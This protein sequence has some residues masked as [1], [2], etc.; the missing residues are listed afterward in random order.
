MMNPW[1]DVKIGEGAPAIVRGIIEIPTNTRAKYEL[2]KDSGMLIMDRVIYS[3][4]YY[5]ANYGFIPRTFCDDNDPLDIMVLSQVKVQPLC[6]VE[7]KVI[8]AMRMLDGGEKD[9]KIIAVARNDMSV[10]HMNDITDLPPHFVKELK[11]FFEDYK[12]LE[13][14]DVVVE[15][16]QNREVALEIV[17]QAMKDYVQLVMNSKV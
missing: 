10:N 7:A 9:D 2:D 15:E 3:S 14:K 16:F 1:H 11:T 5:P 8:G 6:I 4:M 12:K 13:N 17:H